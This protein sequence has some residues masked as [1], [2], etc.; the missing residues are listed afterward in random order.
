MRDFLQ[1]HVKHHIY[2]SNLVHLFM[3]HPFRMILIL[4]IMFFLSQLVG[5]IVAN[6]YIDPVKSLETGDTSF[7]E[8]PSIGSYKFERPDTSP[9]QSVA[10][11]TGMIV[12]ATIL[13]LFF[14]KFS[15]P[16]IW[17]SWFFL[18]SLVCLT[19]AF[20]A[21]ISSI[22]A[23]ALGIIFSAWKIFRR[24]VIIHNLTELF[25]YAGLAMFFIPIFSISSVVVLLILIS[26]YDAFA[27]W[28]SKHMITLAK[29][30]TDSGVFAGLLIPYSFKEVYSKKNFFKNP[31]KK[32]SSKSKISKVSKKHKQSSVKVSLLGGGDMAFPL[33]FSGV[34]LKSFG[35]MPALIVSLSA[36]VT[37]GLLFLYGKKDRFYP[38]MPYLSAGC[39]VGLVF[40]F[41][42]FA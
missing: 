17:K 41:M 21:F 38:A 7:K 16:W 8:L 12:I 27:V 15:S 14:S 26:L 22:L 2:I 11:I 4:S 3:K 10:L 42:F 20:S 39:F 30:Q 19:I 5:L 13:I 9:F 40:V 34:V 36:T 24:G 33:V 29:S 1:S 6:Q 31:S 32:L 28:K 35:F 25:V 37:L 23:L 18:A